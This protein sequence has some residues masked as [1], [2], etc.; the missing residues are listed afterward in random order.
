VRLTY[1]NN[2]FNDRFQGIPERG[3][4]KFAEAL[5]SGIEV[6]TGV[7]F[8]VEASHWKEE[9][10]K[11]VFTGRVDAYF[12]ERLGTLEYR[13]LRFVESQLAHEAG[14]GLE[15]EGLRFVGLGV[16]EHGRVYR[17]ANGDLRFEA[18]AG[19][20]GQASFL[21][22]LADSAGRI[23][24]RRALVD[25]YDDEKTLDVP[26]DMVKSDDGKTLHWAPKDPKAIQKFLDGEK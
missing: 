22:Q 17:D 9:A 24:T 20:S 4:T 25:V 10:V 5:L 21:Y 13:S 18:E 26:C 1:D 2:Y 12:G 8:L 3:Y 23:I 19:F 14:F 16:A 6:K 7:D 15:A 11:I